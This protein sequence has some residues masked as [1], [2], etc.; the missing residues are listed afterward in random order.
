MELATKPD[1][2]KTMQRFEAWWHCEVLDRPPVNMSVASNKPVKWPDKKHATQRERWFDLDYHFACRDAWVESRKWVADSFPYVYGNMGPEIL[3][4][5]YGAELEFTPDTSWSKPICHSSRDVLK[6]T[7]NLDS[8][9]WNWI[10]KFTARSLEQGQGRWITSITDLHTHAD[11]LAALREPQDL[12]MELMDDYDAVKL[13]I[14]H[15]TP[16]F[17]LVYDDQA[18]PILSAGQPT[19]SWLPAPHAGRGCVLQADF[20][21]MVSP[22]MFQDVFLPA[23]VYEM[24]RLDR[25]IYH[26]DGPNALQHLD[27]LLACPKLNAIQWVYGASNGPAR[28]W[29]DVY[30]RI[31]SAG[32]G[33]QIYCESIDDALAVAEHVKPNGCLFD[34]AGDYDETQINTF[35]SKLERWSATGKI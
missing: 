8:E 2:A 33:M 24:D 22:E 11:L 21:C 17:D 31:Q 28:K 3:A 9:Y 25:S 16:L 14:Q 34:V 13:A 35:L 1:F 30:K 32:K 10:R 29:I 5:L 23:L 7:P 4:T 26:L 15:L 19:L 18:R 20:I 12:L 27:A 6:L